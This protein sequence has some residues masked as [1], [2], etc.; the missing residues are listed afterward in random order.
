MATKGKADYS[1]KNNL[2]QQLDEIEA[3]QSIYS[4]PGEFTIE[5][6]N[7]FTCLKGF[8]QD[9][10]SNHP[11]CIE[12]TVHLTIENSLTTVGGET[13]FDIEVNCRLSTGYPTTLYPEV[14]IHS[15]S[16]TR[17]GQDDLNKDLQAFISNELV[18][19]NACLLSVI[20]WAR[21]KACQHYSPPVLIS[22]LE[23]EAIEPNEFCRM[24]LYMH[25]IYSKT[26]RRNILSLASELDVTGFC[27]PGKPGVVCIE[28]DSSQ[29]KQ[30]YDIL[31]RWNW[32]SVT[33]RK[34]ELVKDVQNVDSERKIAGFNEL[35]FDTH[36]QRSNHM[37]LGQ[38]RDYLRTHEL[39]YMFKDLF[40][41]S[42]TSSTFKSSY[43]D[44]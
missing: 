3:L 26:K 31:R 6:Y 19:G 30:F 10:H 5:D 9:G 36:G 4:R 40:G 39:E 29:T 24:W 2:E 22:Q 13:E 28:G 15:D 17:K 18:L 41:V 23:E 27:L 16:L 44:C 35:F 42:D 11:K 38:F 32:K 21:E 1:L 25:H 8:I 20:E 34:R 14:H 43:Q 7:A 12:C 37:D 33:C